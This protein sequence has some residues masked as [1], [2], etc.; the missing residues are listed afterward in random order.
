MICSKIFAGFLFAAIPAASLVSGCQSSTSTTPIISYSDTQRIDR[1][2]LLIDQRLNIASQVAKAK[3]NSDAAIDDALRES[4]ILDDLT[5]HADLMK[6][7]QCSLSLVRRFFQNQFD[8]GKI[9]QRHL[10]ADWRNSFPPKYKFNDAPNLACDIRPQLDKLTLELIKA[11]CE[12]QPI[13]LGPREHNYLMNKALHIIRDDVDGKARSQALKI[14][15]N[16]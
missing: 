16:E 9:I 8:A 6:P 3:W 10:V 11:F 2:L 1:L 7:G 14:F 5:V 15:L 12:V 4:Q 13:L